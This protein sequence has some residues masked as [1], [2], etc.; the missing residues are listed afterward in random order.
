MASLKNTSLKLFLSAFLLLVFT[1]YSHSAQADLTASVTALGDATIDPNELEQLSITLSN[2]DPVNDI[3]GAAFSNTLPGT[4]PDGLRVAGSPTY[5]CANGAG[6]VA[7]T[8]SFTAVLGSQTLT[9]SGATIPMRDSG[10]SID[11][12]CTIIIP[13]TAGTSDGSAQTYNYVIASGAVTGTGAGAVS[14]SGAVNQSINVS[15]ASRPV[16]SKS[17]GSS[18]LI[19]GG[20]TTTLTITVTNPNS[21]ALPNFDITDDFPELGGS[22]I[23]QVAATPNA[24]S[25]CTGAGV[26]PTFTPSATAVSVNA[27]GGTIAAS[28]SCTITVDVEAR[29]TNSVYQTAFTNNT[30]DGATDFSNDIGLIPLDAS[31]SVRTQSPLRV[32][33]AFNNA[34]IASG[35]SDTLSITFFNDGDAPLTINS[36]TDSPIDGVGD[37]SFGLKVDSIDAMTCTGGTPGTFA[38]TTSN[39]GIEH[40]TNTT[41]NAGESCTVVTNFTATAETMNVP[42]SF[43]NTISEGDVGTTT[44][45]VVSQAASASILVSDELRILK[46]VSPTN[47]APG[48]PVRYQITVQNWSTSI[49][50][51]VD[52]SDTFTNGQTL[53][54]D[55]SGGNVFAPSVTAGC[56]ALG[57]TGVEGDS[58]VD[59]VIPTLPAR[60]SAFS[61]GTCVITFY[62]MTDIT[63]TDGSAV[64]NVVGAGDVC[65]NAG[66]N[67]NG[68]ASNTVTSNVDADT[69]TVAKHRKYYVY[70]FFGGYKNVY[71]KQRIFWW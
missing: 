23:I 34:A 46:S 40:S 38:I 63:A 6:S 12:T 54:V 25:S 18:T 36:F 10:M 66:A 51:N 45:G 1:F 28:G 65:Y 5:T 7:T 43:T 19:L 64:T 9:L 48:N 52:V 55:P 27:T 11:G 20:A 15:P 62:T 17:F 4:L 49:R 50:T 37:L 44:A 58:D 30:I 39:L 8:G 22:S 59:F 31:A 16:V 47:P 3:T 60:A 70:V 26:A 2:N 24:T 61:P 67:C 13:V 41:I 69:I 57:V 35:Q 32:T 71:T 53:L 42:R 21:F 56:G 68:S 14:N 33:K 29:Q